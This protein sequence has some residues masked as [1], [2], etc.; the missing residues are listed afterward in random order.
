MVFLWF[1]KANSLFKIYIDFILKDIKINDDQ[2]TET[3]P[4]HKVKNRSH[5]Y[6]SF[7]KRKIPKEIEEEEFNC[8]ECDFQTTS[9]YQLKKHTNLKHVRQEIRKDDSIRCK[10]C[11]KHFVEFEEFM[12]HRKT[13]HPG[14]VAQ[15]TKYATGNCVSLPM[16]VGGATQKWKKQTEIK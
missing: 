9:T 3:N 11:G 1:S 12:Y 5:D 13:Q 7:T 10:Y 15:C 6:K 8:L 16:P 14:V 4:W 2:Y